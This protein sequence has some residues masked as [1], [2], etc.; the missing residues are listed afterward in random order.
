MKWFI[1]FYSLLVLLFVTVLSIQTSL[2]QNFGS[3]C[4]GIW[5]GTML[6]YAKGNIRDSIPVQLTVKSIKEKNSWQWKMEYFAVDTTR[7]K[8]YIL[9][10]PDDTSNLYITDEGDGI[11][12]NGYL[13]GPKLYHVFETEGIILTSSYELLDDSTLLFEVNSG[14]EIKED[15]SGESEIRNYS[16]DYLQ[17]VVLK[18]NVIP[19]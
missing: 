2:A 1:N 15:G 11:T 5:S 6:M 8:D 3:Q 10:Y 18:R 7:T 19:K 16:I 9:N 4:E 13:F 17:R 12:L 14:G